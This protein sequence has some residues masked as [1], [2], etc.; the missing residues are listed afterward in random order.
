MPSWLQGVNAELIG[1][2]TLMAYGHCRKVAD[3]G[4]GAVSRIIFV[5]NPTFEI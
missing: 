2:V 4:V 3:A 1:D 5:W